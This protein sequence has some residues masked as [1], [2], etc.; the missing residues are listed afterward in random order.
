MEPAYAVP[1]P[2]ADRAAITA[3]ASAVSWGAILAGA[4]AAGALSLILVFLGFGL[5]M[6]LI[7]PWTRDGSSTLAALGIGSILWITLTQIAA[8]SLGGYLAGRLRTR[9][10]NTQVDEVYFRDT[11]H[12]F[13]SWAVATLLVAGFLGSV[14]GS[15]GKTTAEVGGEALKGAGNVAAVAAL[16]SG[17]G[18][19]DGTAYT[20][21]RLLRAPAAPT[22]QSVTVD[23]ATGQTTTQPAPTTQ[24]N[25]GQR[26]EVAR[27]FANAA[28]SGSLP[29]DDIKYLAQ[30]IAQRTGM[31]TAEAEAQVRNAQAQLQ[32]AAT[33][34]K[35]AADKARKAAAWSSLWLF[36]ALL[37]GAFFA[38]WF[39]TLGGR[40]RDDGR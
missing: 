10:T 2:P 19:D 34:A 38:S 39:A 5:G 28:R 20:I 40:L 33:Q 35:E 3:P 27:I 17:P 25:P 9:W 1:V 24:D 11:A 7:S 4:A 29:D 23:A 6:S 30:L 14:I 36:I 21:D 8:A 18:G 15:V 13:L 22:S 37:G 31:G 16:R 12:G 32:Q 26:G